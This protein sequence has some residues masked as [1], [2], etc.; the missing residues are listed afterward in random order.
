MYDALIF[1]MLLLSMSKR[2]FS[3]L[4]ILKFWNWEIL[5]LQFPNLPIVLSQLVYSK[6]LAT[7]CEGSSL[8]LP[9]QLLTPGRQWYR[10]Q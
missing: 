10:R 4:S 6:A 5:K 3:I 8:G 2:C 7:L 1:F 9:Q